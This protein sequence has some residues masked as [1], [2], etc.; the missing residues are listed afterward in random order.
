MYWQYEINFRLNTMHAFPLGIF[1]AF[2]SFV[3]TMFLHTLVYFPI[4]VY[5]LSSSLYPP[6]NEKSTTDILQRFLHCNGFSDTFFLHSEVLGSHPNTGIFISSA[7]QK[8]R[9]LFYIWLH[10]YWNICNVIWE[11]WIY[12][13]SVNKKVCNNVKKIYLHRPSKFKW[14]SGRGDFSK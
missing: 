8:P 14:W 12:W 1:I 3:I 9:R 2:M 13:A 4:L 5:F 7:I 11:F 6:I 10:V